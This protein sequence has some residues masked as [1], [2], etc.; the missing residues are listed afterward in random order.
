MS[1][2]TQ[3][4]FDLAERA[5]K[6]GIPGVFLICLRSLIDLVR[7][8]GWDA[9]ESCL[10]TWGIGLIVMGVLANTHK[11]KDMTVTNAAKAEIDRSVIISAVTPG[12]PVIPSSPDPAVTREI[13]K[14]V[15]ASNGIPKT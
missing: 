14:Q 12:P 8:F 2:W 11:L 10:E 5:G 6:W 7:H 4:L 1:K 13:D 9:A 3:A 15:R